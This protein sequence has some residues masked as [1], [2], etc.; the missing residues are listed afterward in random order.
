MKKQIKECLWLPDIVEK[1]ARKHGVVPEEVEAVFLNNPKIFFWEKGEKPGEDLYH[2]LGRTDDGRYLAIFYIL[3]IGGEA[4]II[5][6]RDMDRKDK[7]RYE[8]K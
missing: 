7:N 2:A 3:K 6:A 5:S 1:L 8:K 4:L